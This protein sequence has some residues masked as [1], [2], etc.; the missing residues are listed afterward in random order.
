MNTLTKIEHVGYNPWMEIYDIVN[1]T[2]SI[3][4]LGHCPNQDFN[5]LDMIYQITHSDD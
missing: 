1:E 5:Y 4:I 2:S 3:E